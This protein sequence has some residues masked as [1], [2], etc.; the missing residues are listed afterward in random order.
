M[1]KKK[2]KLSKYNIFVKNKVRSGLTFKQ[3][4]R[5]WKGGK[6]TKRKTKTKKGVSTMVRRRRRSTRAYSKRRRSSGI[7]GIKM[8]RGIFPVS[9][10]ISAALVGAGIA[11]MQEQFLPQVIPYQSAALGFAVGGIGGAAGALAKTMLSGGIATGT[12]AA[13]SAYSY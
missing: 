10:I 4:A 12:T 8:T 2:R 7:G 9:G 1:V 13:V 5:A 6:T 11:A 3:A